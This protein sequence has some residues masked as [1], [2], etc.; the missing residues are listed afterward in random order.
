MRGFRLT[1]YAIAFLFLIASMFFSEMTT[2]G[3]GFALLFLIIGVASREF[4]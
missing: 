2:G 4:K 1:M 3:M